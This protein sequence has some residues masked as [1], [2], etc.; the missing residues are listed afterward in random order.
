MGLVGLG[1]RCRVYSLIHTLMAHL[2]PLIGGIPACLEFG[3]ALLR[4]A[5]KLCQK[6]AVPCWGS[7]LILSLG[8]CVSPPSSTS[9]R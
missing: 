8:K 9:F 2:T 7:K 3:C 5:V 4:S 1:D 6:M